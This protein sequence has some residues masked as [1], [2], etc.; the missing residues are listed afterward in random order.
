MI[1]RAFLIG[2][3]G[4]STKFKRE[5]SLKLERPV[6][7]VGLFPPLKLF[8]Y[9]TR[10]MLEADS[11]VEN[12]LSSRILDRVI[13]IKRIDDQIRNALDLSEE[14]LVFEKSAAIFPLNFLTEKR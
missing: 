9:S 6:W 11:I 10:S 8:R 5:S 4:F 7:E 14:S 13:I 1:E 3:C 2:R 12:V